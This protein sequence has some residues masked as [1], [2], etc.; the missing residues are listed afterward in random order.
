MHMN[1]SIE[2]KP[3]ELFDK[4]WALLTAGSI[5]NHNSMTISWG[6]TGTLWSKPVATVYV[7][8]CRY[9]HDFMEENDY[10]VL[11]F[12]P[13]EYRRNLGVMGSV[14]GRD[15]DKDKEGKLTPVKHGDVVIYQEAELT[16]VCKKI[17]Q[18]DL[19]INVIPEEE[20]KRHYSSQAPHTMYIGEIVEIINK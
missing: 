17:Y 15:V 7:K 1:K 19:D 11:S 16:L 12:F 2:L 18:N 10:F 8:P 5:D 20:I 4:Q 6:G 9:T 14:S 13:E 3:F